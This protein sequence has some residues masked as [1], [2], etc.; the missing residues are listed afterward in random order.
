MTC[1]AVVDWPGTSWACTHEVVYTSKHSTST[2]ANGHSR[3]SNPQAP[4]PLMY[5]VNPNAR[6]QVP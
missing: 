4:V 6:L 5:A 2:Q 1:T 3:R